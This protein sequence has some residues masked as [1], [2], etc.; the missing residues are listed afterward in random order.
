M[1]QK[2]FKQKQIANADCVNNV[3]KS[4]PHRI[5]MTNIDKRTIHKKKHDRVCAQLHFKICKET[6]VKFRQKHWYEH[7]PVSVETS[8]EDK[9]ESRTNRQNHSLR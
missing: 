8:Q 9:V 4:R 1:Q 6:G 2:Y 5:S 7:V 3:M